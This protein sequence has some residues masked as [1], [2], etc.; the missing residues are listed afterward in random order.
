MTK[1]ICLLLPVFS[2]VSAKPLPALGE[3]YA[4]VSRRQPR[5]NEIFGNLRWLDV[6][7]DVNALGLH[8]LKAFMTDPEVVL[9]QI[10]VNPDNLGA[11]AVRF[12]AP[13]TLEAFNRNAVTMI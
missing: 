5:R 3:D 4:L 10:V 7:M 6:H 2:T 1:S 13:I 8:T 9:E 12:N 11:P